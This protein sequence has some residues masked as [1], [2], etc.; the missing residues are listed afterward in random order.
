VFAVSGV[1]K[2]AARKA[3]RTAQVKNETSTPQA[4]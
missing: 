2:E 1:Q 3:Q 4:R